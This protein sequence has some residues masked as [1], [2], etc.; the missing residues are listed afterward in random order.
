MTPG[1]KPEA[2][3]STDRRSD[4]GSVPT[5]LLHE[6]SPAAI[7]VRIS[8]GN[9]G[10]YLRDFVYG[11]I[12]GAI[13]SFAVVA[14][15]YGAGFSNSVVIIMGVANLVADGFSMA[16]GNFLGERAVHAE[17]IQ[18]RRIE[19]EHIAVHPAGEAAEIREIFK[20]KGF[21]GQVLE[22]IVET[23]TGN[24]SLW[25]ETMLREEWGLAPP[26]RK[27]WKSGTATFLAF[28][29]VGAV[30]LLPYVAWPFD[31][32]AG[33][34]FFSS[35]ALT[36]AALFG[37]GAVKGRLTHESVLRAGLETLAVGGGAA[38]LAYVI[39]LWLKWLGITA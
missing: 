5:E 28:T 39:G 17:R 11:G 24:R 29:I 30:P 34:R 4:P 15:A 26:V 6:H 36:F 16:A 31:G 8:S 32:N 3:D 1:P 10:S 27:P 12:D 35:V 25:I 14:G 2:A 38:A 7:A 21:D 37:V 22:S 19:E 23:I 9:D 33:T 18:A 13:T 20:Q